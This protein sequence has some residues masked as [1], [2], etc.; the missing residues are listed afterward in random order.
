MNTGDT[1]IVEHQ[2]VFRQTPNANPF[3]DKGKFF[4]DALTAFYD[5]AKTHSLKV[6]IGKRGLGAREIFEILKKN[7]TKP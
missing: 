2:I 4:A 1:R 3:L 5:Q 6:S 7:S